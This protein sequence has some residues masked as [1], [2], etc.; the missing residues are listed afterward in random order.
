MHHIVSDGWSLEVLANDFLEAYS[1]N[2]IT[3]SRKKL[4]IHYKDYAVWQQLRLKKETFQQSGKY[5]QSIFSENIPILN[6][7]TY[8]PRSKNRKGKTISF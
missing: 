4:N 5:W 6:M 3:L 7:P 2:E 8:Q 1:S